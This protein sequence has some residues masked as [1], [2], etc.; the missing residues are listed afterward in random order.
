MN[1]PIFYKAFGMLL[2]SAFPIA[3]LPRVAPAEPDVR[4]VQAD[5]SNLTPEQRVFSGPHGCFFV[6]LDRC[7]HRITG[8]NLIQ[9][10]PQENCDLSKLGVYLT[11][12]CMGAVMYQRGIMMLHG[13]CVT[14]GTRAIVLTGDSGAGKSTLAAEF[15]RRGWM[16]ISD[17]VCA[18]C[19]PEG[20]PLV[21]SSYPSQ[22]L[23]QDALERYER[24]SEDIHSLYFTG[25]REKFGVDVT[26]FFI[27]GRMPLQ[28]VFRL[29]PGADECA[30]EPLEGITKV[31]QL[32]KN[33]YRR[34]LIE[35]K[36]LQRHFQRCITL[37]TKIRM[38]V[39]T[40]R[41]GE[42]CAARMYELITT[43]LEEHYHD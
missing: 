42:D 22:K 40:R 29:F 43:F 18:I 13:S 11:G 27:D 9:V 6:G 8:G 12:T 1:N 10:D 24:S 16:L 28:A 37:S 36:N 3:Q 33:T 26:R 25:S 14:D 30:L 38:A 19:D 34:E 2:E 20:E 21:Q 15:L 4:I 17:D 35:Q 31:D 5:L 32:M 23:W 39:V 41:D 7:A